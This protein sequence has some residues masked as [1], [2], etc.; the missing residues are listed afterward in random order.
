MDEEISIIGTNTRNEKIINFFIKNKK[1][2]III[3]SST[4]LLL[5]V[6]FSYEEINERKKS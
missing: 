5:A 2:L 1:T 6:Y 4:V 3:I